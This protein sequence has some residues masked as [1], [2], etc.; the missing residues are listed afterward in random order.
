VNYLPLL[1]CDGVKS[2]IQQPHASDHATR[3]ANGKLGQALLIVIFKRCMDRL[4]FVS[5]FSCSPFLFFDFA[6]RFPGITRIAKM[7]SKYMPHISINQLNRCLVLGHWKIARRIARLMLLRGDRRT[8]CLGVIDQKHFVA[9]CCIFLPRQNIQ[10]EAE[11]F[12]SG[13]GQ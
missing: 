9:C 1:Y 4:G 3:S 7:N 13:L 6:K 10:G 8:S 11:T 2:S 12:E 5:T